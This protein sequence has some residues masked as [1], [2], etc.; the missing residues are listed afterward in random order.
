MYETSI[1]TKNGTEYQVRS[2]VST[3]VGITSILYIEFIGY[4]LLDIVTAFSNAE[5]TSYISGYVE[6]EL[7]KE[8]RNYTNLIEAYVIAESKNVHI[9]L[10]ATQEVLQ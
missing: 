7:K 1:K 4:S 9:G 6:G 2:C 8:Y 10:T 5:E 3:T